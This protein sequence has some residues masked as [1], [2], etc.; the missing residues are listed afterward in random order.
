MQTEDLTALITAAG[1]GRS[2]LILLGRLDQEGASFGDMAQLAECVRARAASDP[3]MRHDRQIGALFSYLSSPKCK[4]F[5]ESAVKVFASEGDFDNLQ[6]AGGSE[7]LLLL[8]YIDNH[9]HKF[10]SFK[11]YASYATKC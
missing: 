7:T 11:V 4:L 10:T 1:S 9:N 5:S 2:A 6:A 3:A 8:R